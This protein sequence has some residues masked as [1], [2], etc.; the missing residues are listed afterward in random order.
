[1]A[2]LQYDT[3]GTSELDRELT[4]ATRKHVKGALDSMKNPT[5]EG[6]RKLLGVGY[7]RTTTLVKAFDFRYLFRPWERKAE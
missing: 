3:E 1:M 6:L 7:R 4:K 2:I 5:F